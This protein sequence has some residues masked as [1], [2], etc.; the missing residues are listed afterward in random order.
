LGLAIRPK[1]PNCSSELLKTEA[2]SG[3]EFS[4][5]GANGW[6]IGFNRIKKG[7]KM[8]ISNQ[9]ETFVEEQVK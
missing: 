9:I 6:H 5:I 1:S 2:C 3:G 4:Q 8:R 7:W